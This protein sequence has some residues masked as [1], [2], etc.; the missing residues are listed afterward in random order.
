MVKRSEKCSEIGIAAAVEP[1]RHII[2]AGNEIGFQIDWLNIVFRAEANLFNFQLSWWLVLCR[3][4]YA[5]VASQ[6]AEMRI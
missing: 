1:Y 4:C 2:G 5:R 3:S 6:D